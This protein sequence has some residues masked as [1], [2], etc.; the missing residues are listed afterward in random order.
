MFRSIT[1]ATLDEK[2]KLQM[3]TPAGRARAAEIRAMPLTTRYARSTLGF[4]N[5]L[6]AGFFGVLFAEH[7]G[8]WWAFAVVLFGASVL[9]LMQW[10]TEST[11]LLVDLRDIEEER[12]AIS[13]LAQDDRLA[14]ELPE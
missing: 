3:A 13:A 10:T 4:A 2:Y 1:A 5:A 11:L 7:G 9:L 14:D 12:A 8:L 6:F